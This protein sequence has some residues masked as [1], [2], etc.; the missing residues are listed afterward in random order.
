MKRNPVAAVF[1]ASALS[2][3][4]T[5]TAAHAQLDLMDLGSKLLQRVFGP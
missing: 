5:N 2:G 4:L 3:L 1:A